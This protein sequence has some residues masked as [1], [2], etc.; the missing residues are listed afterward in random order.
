LNDRV[1]NLKEDFEKDQQL[2]KRLEEETKNRRD[3]E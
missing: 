1:K 2:A 3:L